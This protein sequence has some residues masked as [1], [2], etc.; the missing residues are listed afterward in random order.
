MKNRLFLNIIII[1]SLIAA[2]AIYFATQGSAAS[3]ALPSDL[4]KILENSGR[5]EIRRIKVAGRV[6]A[7]TEIKYTVEPQ[8]ELVF[9]IENPPKSTETHSNVHIPVIYKGLKPDMFAAG[10]D[11]IVEGEFKDGTLYANN[12]MTQCPSKYEA[13]LPQ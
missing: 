5:S 6:S 3:M 4:P 10:R 12:L 2:I 8:I 11:V 9:G 7:D 13:P 1:F